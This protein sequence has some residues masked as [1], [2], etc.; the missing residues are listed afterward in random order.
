MGIDRHESAHGRAVGPERLGEGLVDHHGGGNRRPILGA[1]EPPQGSLDVEGLEE[2]G[3]H[4]V[5]GSL[6]RLG[7]IHRGVP[8]VD[9][10]G[11]RLP[12]EREPAGEARRLHS[13]QR[14]DPLHDPVVQMPGPGHRRHLVFGRRELHGEE[15]GG[16]EAQGHLP[17]VVHGSD[18]EGRGD[19]EEG[20]QGGLDSDETPLETGPR[21]RHGLQGEAPLAQEVDD[22]HSA[23]NQPRHPGHGPREAQHGGGVDRAGRDEGLPH[24]EP[25]DPRP[26]QG[27]GP[28]PEADGQKREDPALHQELPDDAPP[29]G[30][31]RGPDRQLP[32]ALDRPSQEKV[33]HVQGG[34]Q[35]EEG[36]PA[37]EEEEGGRDQPALGL[38][39]PGHR[40]RPLG[41]ARRVEHGEEPGEAVR[42]G[43]QLGGRVVETGA[44]PEDSHRREVLGFP[45]VVVPGV[46][47]Q[48]EP[49]LGA[50]SGSV[51]A[52]PL[53]P[54][55]PDRR[56]AHLDRAPQ[57][58]RIRTEGAAPEGLADHRHGLGAHDR[59]VVGQGPAQGGLDGQLPEELR[60]DHHAVHALASAVRPAQGEGQLGVAAH[61]PV[62]GLLV[63]V[64]GE[65]PVG[66]LPL[67]PDRDRPVRGAPPA[68]VAEG[69]VHH[70]EDRG[71]GA[72]PQPQHR[73]HPHGEAGVLEDQAQGPAQVHDDVRV[74]RRRV[75]PPS[76]EETVG[77]DRARLEGV[78][79]PGSERG[80][81]GPSPELL[82]EVAQGAL[83]REPPGQDPL[84]DS[85]QPAG[86]AGTPHRS[87]APS[88]PSH[89]ARSISRERA[90]I[91]W[92]A[93][94]TRT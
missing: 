55:D 12:P 66:E 18:Q 27:S 16:F 63:P 87:R 76:T 13:G 53:D 57:H 10:R 15:P 24:E 51:P 8:K 69:P 43:R 83:A 5:H 84:Q 60:G 39:G 75:G 92:P 90:S 42:E 59:V 49:E 77:H 85:L 17:E 64:E 38:A 20:R 70:G 89:R 19:Q 21:V 78:P 82:G 37:Q 30:P 35:E 31:D 2:P 48:G 86:R 40:G 28:E 6:D 23:E 72:K 67:G 14:S 32:A 29:P 74:E 71:V 44:V 65:H 54:H 4:H 25:G 33:A 93:G 61:R 7:G 46:H 80:R 68:G 58:R 79:E 52:R 62:R 41:E 88:R 11:G 1:Q 91:L 73:D 81:A 56:S 47:R 9:G 94:V 3:I 34:D 36:R 26:G 22:R 50:S 45:V